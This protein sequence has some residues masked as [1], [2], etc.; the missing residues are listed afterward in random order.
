MNPIDLTWLSQVKAFAEVQGPK[1]DGIISDQITAFSKWVLT[2]CGKDTLN[3]VQS[4]N[5]IYNGNGSFRLFLR[6]SPIQS[7]SLVQVGPTALPLSQGFNQAGVFIEQSGKSIAIRAVGNSGSEISN[8]YPSLGNGYSFWK[9]VGN[10]QVQYTA[11]Y[12]A[13]TQTNELETIASQTIPLD[14]PTWASDISVLFYP[15]LVAL[16]KVPSAPTTGQY[17][18]SN[19]IYVF[20]AGD[21]AK[22]VLVSYTYNAP[23]PDLEF[24]CRRTVGT[25]YK[26]RAWLDQKSKSISAQGATGTTSYRDWPLAPEDRIT[27]NSYKRYA[28]V[29]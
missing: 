26:R 25:W 14:F 13:Q 16:T 10:V 21:N 12:P 1:D 24:A 17:A 22:Q 23:P 29:G 7:L 11:G 3:T 28:L 9:G 20:A 6:N 5:E 2:Y 15:S 19:G 27:I 8:F 4:F 18:V